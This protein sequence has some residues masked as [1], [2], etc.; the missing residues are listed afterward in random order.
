MKH[1]FSL[2]GLIY[3]IAGVVVAVTH[4]YIGVALLKGVASALLCIFLWF[5]PLLGVSLHIH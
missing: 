4:H 2:I 5:L 1:G 3:L